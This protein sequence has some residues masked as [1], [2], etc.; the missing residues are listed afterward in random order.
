MIQQDQPWMPSDVYFG[1]VDSPLPDWRKEESD[2]DR[3]DDAELSED[4]RSALISILGFDPA[5][6]A[7]DNTETAFSTDA[8]GHEHKG[9]GEGGGQFTTKSNTDLTRSAAFKSWFGDWEKDPDSASKVVDTNG[10]PQ[11][12]H[13]TAKKVFHGRMVK[14]DTFDKKKI[15][16]TG[17]NAGRGFY[18]AEN[19]V[20]AQSYAKEGKEIGEVIECYLSIKNPFDLDNE[21]NWETFREFGRRKAS[22]EIQKLGYDGIVY[23][24]SDEEGTVRTRSSQPDFGKCWV[25]F[26]P[27]QIKSTDNA[28][29]FDP[30]N[31]SI[32]M[33]INKHQQILLHCLRE[34]GNDVETGFRAAEY[35]VSNLPTLGGMLLSTDAH[36]MEH[37]GK[38]E[39]GGQFTSKG[40]SVPTLKKP[41]LFSRLRIK[42]ALWAHRLSKFERSSLENYVDNSHTINEAVRNESNLDKIPGK[43]GEQARAIASALEKAPSLGGRKVYRGQQWYKK[44]PE[45][46]ALAEQAIKDGGVLQFSGF[47]SSTLDPKT[48]DDFSSGT[49]LEII[50]AHQGA[51]LEPNAARKNKQYEVLLPHNS[52][53]RVLEVTEDEYP[54]DFADKPGGT[55]KVKVIRMEQVPLS[56]YQAYQTEKTDLTG[57]SVGK[58]VSD[59]KSA[60]LS[61]DA[62]GHEHKGKVR[63]SGRKKIGRKRLTAEILVLLFGDDAEAVAE[64]LASGDDIDANLSIMLAT[65]KI[66]KRYGNQ[67]GPGWVPGGWSRSGTQIWLWRPHVHT[68]HHVPTPVA[69][70]APTPAPVATPVVPATPAVTPVSTR[71]PSPRKVNADAAY[72]ATMTKLNA[73]QTLTIAE[74]TALGPHLS[75]MTYVQLRAL[76]S[77]LGGT[78][79]IVGSN[80]TSIVATVRATLAGSATPPTP[81]PA[82]TPV[83]PPP[84][85]ATPTPPPTPITPT[86]VVPPAAA[87]TPTPS[88]PLVSPAMAALAPNLHNDAGKIRAII[89]AALDNHTTIGDAIREIGNIF[90]TLSR[91]ERERLAKA[92]GVSP[93][94]VPNAIPSDFI[95]AVRLND[96][97]HV[98]VSPPGPPPRPGL[99]WNPTTHRWILAP[100]ATPAPPLLSPA[101]PFTPPP[102]PATPSTP[103]STVAETVWET[104]KPQ[105]GTLNG[106]DFA[107]APKNFWEKVKDVN[108]NEPPP[109]PG[110]P[111]VRCSVMIQEPDGRIWIVEP[112]NEFGNR[113]HTL[114]GGTVEKGL[115]DQQNALK[116]TWEETGLQVEITGY[117]GD[118]SDSNYDKPGSTPRHGR[119]YI[120][121]RV[122]GAPWDAKIESHIIDRKT[123]K[124]SAESSTVKLVT[125]ERAAQLLHRTDDLA[126]LATINPI[127]INT[128]SNGEMLKKVVNGLK[129]KAKQY[130]KKKKDAREA[131]GDTL[132]HAVQELRGF[133]GKPKVVNK[134]AFD[135]IMAQD[136]HI[137]LLRGIARIPPSSV[138]GTTALTP[139]EMAEQFKTGDHFPGH[140]IFGVGTYADSN[141]GYSNVATGSYSSG[142]TVI[143]IALPKSAKIAKFTDLKAAT[144]NSP[145]GYEVPPGK[146]ATNYW[147]G[148]HAALAGYD[149]IHVN[150]P[151]RYGDG[152]YVILN[153]SVLTVQDVAPP[154]SYRIK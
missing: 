64:H 93:Q 147:R 18:F 35:I 65:P 45:F 92:F 56:E 61:T 3:D 88:G 109:L 39:G 127:P 146:N 129:P 4:E 13:G 128:K 85:V 122:G 125:P 23:T 21:E 144:P 29:T 82:P 43:I 1:E 141:K 22:D 132:L 124:P 58:K 97:G 5:E 11:I 142:G 44:E 20:V 83:I 80:R 16:K 15:G 57:V 118:F 153:R 152:Y 6:I 49:V 91:N 103:L 47:Q 102:A 66:T 143:R 48:A 69:T 38:G 148:V 94:Y 68:P 113:K 30:A 72:T 90:T 101:P 150:L 10:D 104:G 71:T 17:I 149:A 96:P 87:P 73:G 54:S 123:G 119:L 28:G 112:T 139:E 50:T 133:N 53:F 114:P 99:V 26:E 137:E 138:H 37:K 84:P 86:P 130:E 55:R 135:T 75:Y 111:I 70:P 154:R 25:A 7:W 116:E 117:L 120:G 89:L 98:G 76:H 77:A 121:K 115:T 34:A 36:G 107:P 63:N 108:V 8:H 151:G 9:K 100:V 51:Y 14:F 32:H 95:D 41:G 134:T 67:P 19:K 81:A 106:V 110:K 74:K 140:G 145:N 40:K 24:S 131:P 42:T 59:K 105:P 78:T 60:L 46:L 136:T 126:Q 12:T 2:S 52:M 62:Q 31:D 27:N 33:S 79:A